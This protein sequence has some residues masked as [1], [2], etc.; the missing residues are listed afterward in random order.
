MGFNKCFLVILNALLTLKLV[1]YILVKLL[2]NNNPKSRQPPHTSTFHNLQSETHHLQTFLL[3]LQPLIYYPPSIACNYEPPP[4]TTHSH[5][6]PFST[7]N[8][9][10]SHH[11]LTCGHTTTAQGLRKGTQWSSSTNY[12]GRGF[13]YKCYLNICWWI[14]LKLAARKSLSQRISINIIFQ[15][16]ILI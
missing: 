14:F 2:I 10:S 12:F 16:I 8:H 15:W 5:P 11:S 7:L 9:H 1:K 6:H 13:Y 4:I 3:H